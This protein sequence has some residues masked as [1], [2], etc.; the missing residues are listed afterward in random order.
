MRRLVPWLFT[1]LLVVS[2]GTAFSQSTDTPAT[3]QTE[4][5]SQPAATPG[6]GFD[7][8][9]C[10]ACH[11]EAVFTNFQHSQHAKKIATSCAGCH[12]DVATHA[13][14]KMEGAEGIGPIFSFRRVG[15]RERT[16]RCLGC[17]DRARQAN[18]TGG[19][20]DRRNVDCT[21]CHSVHFFKSQRS[22]LRTARATE[23][24][25]GCHPQVRAQ[26]MRQSHHP[27]REGKMDCGSC[28]DPHSSATRGMLKAASINDLC[29]TCHADK[30][31]PFLWEH[32]PVRENCTTCHTP[33]GSNHE[34]L[35]VAKQPWLCQRCHMATR[36]PGTLYHGPNVVAGANP[37]NRLIE[38]GCRNCH[39]QIHGTNH[40]GSP[41]FGR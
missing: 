5:A 36:H 38:H 7:V 15:P 40:P 9:E 24:C 18:F 12:G 39:T 37:S 29:Y 34:R 41:Y 10:Q 16:E 31:G 3:P 13:R 1:V 19:T 4:P 14:M 32:A 30:R 6:P 22:Q 33:H 2:Y 25:Y 8:A 26:G 35:L 27:V 21:S 23:T 11:A 17:H 28:H 20:H